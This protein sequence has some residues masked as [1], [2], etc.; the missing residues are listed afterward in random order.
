VRFRLLGSLGVEAGGTP[1]ALGPPKQRAVLAVLLLH[2]NEIVPTDRIIDL[3]WGKDPPRTAEH[4]YQP[5]VSVLRE[6]FH[7]DYTQ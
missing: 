6:A 4:S 2:A 1:I 3:V 5:Y 7:K